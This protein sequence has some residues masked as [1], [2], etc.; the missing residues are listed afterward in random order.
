MPDSAS[1]IGQTLSHYRIVEKLGAGG[2]GEVYRARDERLNRDVAFKVLSPDSSSS[3]A[4][5][6]K[7]LR[8]A[9]SASA[10]NDP[11]I[12]TIYEVGEAAG[13]HFIVMELVEGI[14]LN[15]LIAPGG[16]RPELVERYGAQIA[17]ALAH[18]HDRGIIHRDIKSANVVITSSG[19]VKVLDFGLA[20]FFGQLDFTE[21]AGSTKSGIEASVIAGTLPYIAPEILR[22]QAASPRSDIWSLGVTLYEMSTSNRPFRGQTGFEL[23]SGILRNQL[24]RSLRN[25]RQDFAPSSSAVWKKSRVTVTSGQAKSAPHSKPFWRSPAILLRLSPFPQLF[26]S[27]QGETHGFS[28]SSAWQDSPPLYSSS[29]PG[30]CETRFSITPPL[31]G[32]AP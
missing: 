23:T 7:I 10:L 18:A 9:R 26:Q 22:G 8:E 11:H 24:L 27:M 19:Q 25:F 6:E 32:F 21:A 1:L 17:A 3:V 15:S 29:T 12:C 13:L 14:P 16:L 28:L 31:P 5:G 2:M 20:R 4:A 30:V